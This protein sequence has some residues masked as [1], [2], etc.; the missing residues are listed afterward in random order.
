MLSSPIVASTCTWYIVQIL[1][2]S[3]IVLMLS[4]P[5]VEHYCFYM[6]TWC[7]YQ[8]YAIVFTI[9]LCKI[10]SRVLSNVYQLHAI[11]EHTVYII[12]DHK[13]VNPISYQ[14]NMLNGKMMNLY[15]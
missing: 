9:Q 7:E 4:S 13:L 1:C 6:C 15:M 2:G 3:P 10:I 11:G 14:L 12:V 8:L 5:V